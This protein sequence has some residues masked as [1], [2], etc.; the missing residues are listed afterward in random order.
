MFSLSKFSLE[1]LQA[2]VDEYNT[3]GYVVIHSESTRQAIDSL[4]DACKEILARLG[5]DAD[6]I[7][8]VHLT[9]P[10]IVNRY[11][12]RAH[13]CDSVSA[14]IQDILS[15]EPLRRFMYK[16][17][18]KNIHQPDHSI[19]AWLPEEVQKGFSGYHQ[20]GP[21]AEIEYG[22][23]HVWIPVTESRTRNFKIIPGSHVYGNLPHGMLGQFIKVEQSHVDLLSHNE[24][25]LQ[26]NVGDILIFST[27]AL[28]CLMHN[29]SR[30]ICWSLEFVCQA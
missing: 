13:F 6:K 30:Q 17:T 21:A 24:E 20:D 25:D 26:V 14:Q 16:I 15:Q 18:G 22:Y 1:S 29:H 9:H 27:R 2:L 12:P 7:E 10:E 5:V 8:D 4:Y 19:L 23:P 28:H 11:F 3:R